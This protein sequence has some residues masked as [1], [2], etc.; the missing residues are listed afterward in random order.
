MQARS[1]RLF[2]CLRVCALVGGRDRRVGGGG[3]GGRGR[4]RTSFSVADG[5]GQS[6]GRLHLAAEVRV[7]L[8]G[9]RI[10]RC[11][12]TQAFMPLP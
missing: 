7:Y 1:V 2:A 4:G 3:E 8:F 10:A 6:E 11:S 12:V 5:G 9:R